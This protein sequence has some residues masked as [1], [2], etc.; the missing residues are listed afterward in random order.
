M[1]GRAIAAAVTPLRDGGTGID[2]AAFDPLVGLLAG[3]ELD[4][5]LALGTTGEGVLFTPPERERIAER[6]VACRPEGFRILVHCGAQTTAETVR[7]ASHARSAGA[8]GVAVICPPY[9]V[10]DADQQ[11]AHLGA[12]AAA[13][14]PVPF[15]VYEFAARSGYAVD[16]EVVLRLRDRAPNLA[17]L[18]VSDSPFAAVRPYLLDGLDVYVGFEPLTLEAMELGAAGTVSGLATAFPELIARLLRE[19]APECQGEV[20]D[21]REAVA[22]LPFQAAMK[23]VLAARGLPV[24]ED[25]RPPLRPLTPQEHERLGQV[26][27]RFLSEAEAATPRPAQ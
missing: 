14:H 22:P 11:L 8:D 2:E 24:A 1:N 13:C 9:F 16:P 21:L 7:L 26:V 19:R 27:A 5:L 10:L 18:K 12:A 15:Y 17:G 6:F 3:A 4:G 25:V 20:A 23:A